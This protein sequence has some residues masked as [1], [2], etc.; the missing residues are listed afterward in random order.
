MRLFTITLLSLLIVFSVPGP[1][2]GQEADDP[3]Y[4]RIPD[5]VYDSLERRVIVKSLMVGRV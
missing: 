3:R 1:V 5:W 2:S 4:D